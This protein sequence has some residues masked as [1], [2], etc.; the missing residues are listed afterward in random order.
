LKDVPI[1]FDNFIIH[2]VL[3]IT[4]NVFLDNEFKVESNNSI[5]E[6]NIFRLPKDII[7]MIISYIDFKSTWNLRYTCKGF[8]NNASSFYKGFYDAPKFITKLIHEDLFKSK[9]LKLSN[10]YVR[11][12]SLDNGHIIEKIDYTTKIQ[13]MVNDLFKPKI[14]G[15]VE[16]SYSSISM[17]GN[18]YCLSYK[19]EGEKLSYLLRGDFYHHVNALN[20]M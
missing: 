3:K 16:I 15:E 18:S 10:Y 8:H 19:Y 17:E 1:D 11:C 14:I 13:E 9:L 7:D 6:M 20:L 12:G 5:K 2:L 4:E